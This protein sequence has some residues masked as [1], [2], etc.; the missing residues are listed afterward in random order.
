MS[1]QFNATETNT[2]DIGNF[3]IVASSQNHLAPYS[4]K[5][6]NDIRGI[7]F[8]N[9]T[10]GDHF[11]YLKVGSFSVVVQGFQFNILL[12]LNNFS[13]GLFQQCYHFM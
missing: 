4:V 1:L 11:I 7:D 12:N 5:N 9:K 8:S 10:I 6:P 3:S 13:V 2:A